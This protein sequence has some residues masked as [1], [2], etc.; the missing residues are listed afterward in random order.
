MNK[1]NPLKVGIY[2]SINTQEEL[3]SLFRVT[4]ANVADSIVVD[5]EY[6]AYLD[7]EGAIE[8][9]VHVEPMDKFQS[10]NEYKQ[11]RFTKFSRWL[12]KING[13]KSKLS[14]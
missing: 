9:A 13:Q 11:I 4:G 8:G 10:E 7:D 14:S 3:N 2:L 1:Q 6:V 5:K 12:K